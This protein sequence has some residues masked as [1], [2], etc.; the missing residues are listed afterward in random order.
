MKVCW[1]TIR[2]NDLEQSKRF[3]GDVLGLELDNTF[4]PMPGRTIAFF[5]GDEGAEIELIYDE[6]KPAP[7]SDEKISIGFAVDNLELMLQQVKNN[8]VE[9]LKGPLTLGKDTYCFFIKDPNGIEIQ[10]VENKN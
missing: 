9:I 8:N 7:I 6:G 4:S 1:C 5:K 2:V 10:I 3:Y